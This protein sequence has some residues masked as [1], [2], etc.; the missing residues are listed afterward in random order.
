MTISIYFFSILVW[1]T[2]FKFKETYSDD[3]LKYANNLLH[4]HLI[5]LHYFGSLILG[6]YLEIFYLLVTYM[7]STSCGMLDWMKHK[8]GSRCPGEISITSDIQMIPP[9]WH[10][11]KRN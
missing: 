9:L 2:I 5:N 1:H 11:V 8:L 6:V 3:N 7:Q 10:K 4:F